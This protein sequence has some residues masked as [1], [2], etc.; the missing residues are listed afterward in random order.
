MGWNRANRTATCMVLKAT[1]NDRKRRGGEWSW[2]RTPGWRCQVAGS[3]LDATDDP[4]YNLPRIKVLPLEWW[5]S[6]EIAV[7]VQVSSSSHNHD[8]KLGGPSAIALVLRQV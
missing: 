8:S 4:P 5:E 6:S 7:P 3:S 1:A 2:S